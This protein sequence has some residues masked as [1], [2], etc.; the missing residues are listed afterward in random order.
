VRQFIAAFCLSAAAASA[1]GINAYYSGSYGLYALGSVAGASGYGAIDFEQ[2]NHNVLLLAAASDSSS[3][4]IDAVP[5]TRGTSGHITAFGTAAT[6]AT[7]PYIDAGMAYASNG[8]LLYTRNDGTIGELKPG[9]TSPNKTVTSPASSSNGGTILPS[10][11]AGGTMIVASYSAGKICTS[12]LTADGNGTYNLSSCGNS[13]TLT[14]PQGMAWIAAGSPLFYSASL[15][16]GRG[17]SIYAYTADANGLPVSSTGT[18][19]ASF[20][21]AIEGLTLDPV[22]G[23]LLVSTTASDQIYEIQGFA[24]PSSA[25]E[26]GSLVLVPLGLALCCF[27]RRPLRRR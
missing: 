26:P 14:N 2:G 15:L 9:S 25:A 23:D 5:V 3:G 17:G 13:T 12:V 4:V 7:T 1:A 19:F 27:G 10:G 24:A 22:T 16:V 8:D 21:G 11:V 6:F 20:G 18:A